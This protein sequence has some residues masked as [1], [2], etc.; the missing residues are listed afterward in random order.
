MTALNDNIRKKAFGIMKS[1]E[2]MNTKER[3]EHPSESFGKNYNSLRSLCVQNNPELD[4][5]IPPEVKFENYGFENYIDMKTEHSYA[6][7]H[8]YCSEIY[9]LLE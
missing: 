7:I 2:T 4:D 5:L 6:E 8:T 9:H 3:Q 1:I